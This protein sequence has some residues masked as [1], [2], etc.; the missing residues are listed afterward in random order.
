MATVQRV[1]LFS[2]EHP[3]ISES[4][5]VMPALHVAYSIYGRLNATGDN[6]VLVCHALTGDARVGD[7]TGIEDDVR[8]AVPFYKNVTDNDPGWWNG[9]LG[10]GKALDTEKYAVI[11]ANIPGSCYGS[12]GPSDT[13]P[14]FDGPR[15][16][17]L[18]IRDM[19]HVHKALLDNLGVCRLQTVIGGSLG[20]MQALEWALCY[21][22]M[23]AS[24][25]PVATAARHSPWA[26]AFSHVMRQAIQN[27]PRFNAGDYE[28]QP[29]RG[30]SLARQIAMISYRTAGSF[31]MRFGRTRQKG[32]F[33]VQNYLDYQGQK[34]VQRFDANALL[35][36]LDAMDSHDV[37]R[38]RGGINAA[39]G[40][41]TQPALCIG[42][43]SDL[44]YPAWEQQEIAR[45]IP[46]ARYAEIASPHGH[47]AFLIE[48]ERLNQLVAAFLEERYGQ[49]KE[50][51]S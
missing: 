30:L 25:I 16:P 2:E 29:E 18:T 46:G 43:E 9:L 4:G 1:K 36:L 15:F 8:R 42:I 26:M 22:E 45:M 40:C 14:P 10:P 3:F 19:V 32:R 17:A 21:P 24:V 5:T 37:G 49:K 51:A 48:Q 41:I 38:G 23:V 28:Q 11:C 39:L 50:A 20:G 13:P 27:D 33:A 47:D 44:L 12:S 35:V 6:A 34:L 31:G 7:N